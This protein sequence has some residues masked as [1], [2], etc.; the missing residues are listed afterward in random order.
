MKTIIIVLIF[1]AHTSISSQS[2]LKILWNLLAK[3]DTTSISEF[4]NEWYEESIPISNLHKSNLSP[5]I[6]N[7]YDIV[8]CFYKPFRL[9]D[10]NSDLDSN[11]LKIPY[12][13]FP[14]YFTV[15]IMDSLYF[16]TEDFHENWIIEEKE[17]F[18]F[19]PKLFTNT[20]KIL[21]LDAIN[22][23]IVDTAIDQDKESYFDKKVSLLSK[24]IKLH[25]GYWYG[26]SRYAISISTYPYP[27][28]IYFNEAFDFARVFFITSLY[29]AVE[30][31]FVKEDKCWKI[32]KS[33]SLI[34]IRY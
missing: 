11:E 33:K 10:D 30:I 16:K 19:K 9:L 23:L 3:E 7:T 28:K 22:D 5:L 13:I 20:K 15:R 14:T 18:D 8:E 26:I 29:S 31:A 32:D 21:F 4:F 27:S 2:R 34:N 25:K 12:I 6:K 1:F 24:Y 17:C